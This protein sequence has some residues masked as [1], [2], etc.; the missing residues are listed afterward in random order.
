MS[1]NLEQSNIIKK[2]QDELDRIDQKY[3][4]DTDIDN[5]AKCFEKLSAYTR[6]TMDL[7]DSGRH[8]HFHDHPKM[9]SDETVSIK[10]EET[11]AK[12]QLDLNVVRDSLG[13]QEE[14]EKQANDSILEGKHKKLRTEK[15]II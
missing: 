12:I 13:N 15:K 7:I 14:I 4:E 11:K 6:F 8:Y 5:C 10:L 1:E 9:V 2:F 3:P